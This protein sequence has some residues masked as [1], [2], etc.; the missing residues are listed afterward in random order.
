MDVA[1]PK[2]ANVDSDL[3]MLAG[4]GQL[5]EVQ[6]LVEAGLAE[7]EAGREP[8]DDDAQAPFDINMKDKRGLSPLTLACRSGHTKVAGFL[9]SKG[10]DLEQASPGGLRPLH[11]AV[12]S[13]A[14]RARALRRDE[15]ERDRSPPPF[16]ADR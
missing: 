6:G 8:D 1:I 4:F 10:A 11:H 9:A 15:A 3:C 2:T 12:M 16:L 7:P 5:N 14:E 13:T